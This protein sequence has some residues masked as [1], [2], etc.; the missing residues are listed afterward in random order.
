MKKEGDID[1]KILRMVE[2]KQLK[3]DFVAL[4]SNE[5]LVDSSHYKKFAYA[6]K[7]D[8]LQMQLRS[9][10]EVLLSL[11][12]KNFDNMQLQRYLNE[13][14][15]L[16]TPTLK[17]PSF[18]EGIMPYLGEQYE[19]FNRIRAIPACKS[20]YINLQQQKEP[21]FHDDDLK[22]MKD[23]EKNHQIGHSQFQTESNF[24][25]VSSH[26]PSEGNNFFNFDY[27]RMDQILEKGNIFNIP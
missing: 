19:T 17:K 1:Q 12:K 18:E 4:V 15:Y 27:Y 8:L 5:T 24:N 23:L 10:E 9:S 22:I 26:L 6:S 16:L 11:E 13:F 2:L 21:S 7:V 3:Y 25:T 20:E 14:D